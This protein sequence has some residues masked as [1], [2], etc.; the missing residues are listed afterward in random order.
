MTFGIFTE[1]AWLT[2]QRVQ[3]YPRIFAAFS[4]I[5]TVIWILI[6]DGWVDPIGRPIGTDFINVH[7]AGRMVLDGH[8][9][10]VYDFA[11]H[12]AIERAILGNRLDGYYGWH[13][14][15]MLLGA[16]ALLALLPYGAALGTWMAMTLA[17]YVAV[18]RRLAPGR[19][20][21]WVA[22]G[23]PAVFVNLGHGQN[24]FVTTALFGGALLW[25]EQRP[26]LAGVLFG[27]LTYKPQF[28]ILVPVALACG[29]HWRAFAAATATTIAL[30]MAS[31]AVFGTAT[32][33]AFV[34]SLS[35]TTR[36]VLGEGATGFEKF[37]SIFA[38][39][40]LWGAGMEVAFA[41]QGVTILIAATA[42]AW[43]WRQPASAAVRGASLVAASALCS[44]YIFDYDLV[45]L[46]L[47]IAWLAMEGLRRGFL[48]GEKA[49]LFA[50]WVLPIVSRMVA[51]FTSVPLGPF[52]I[53][54]LLA[55][56]LRRAAISGGLQNRLL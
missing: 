30:G 54:A 21:L 3:V 9:A 29:G 44:P 48:P 15:P 33:R 47:P 39:M 24:G 8:P 42:V 26:V 6:T 7:A 40:R 51:S 38:A 49:V 53:G 32:W 12:G 27:L 20:A 31:W 28:G 37:Q 14:P 36:V 45:L 18:L 2:S 56:A 50:A 13:Y 34:G 5:I 52:V 46:A 17:G 16:A 41:I 19:D 4:V 1:A 22:L 10:A 55:L 35:L 43:T 25:L 11:A 23:F